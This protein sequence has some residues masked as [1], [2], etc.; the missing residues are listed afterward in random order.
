MKL[1]S[2]SS[3]TPV[4]EKIA[5]AD[6]LNARFSD[7]LSIFGILYVA[8]NFKLNL[9]GCLEASDFSNVTNSVLIELKKTI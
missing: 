5:L 9:I 1:S 3:R 7:E 6:V 4:S 8:S 2:T